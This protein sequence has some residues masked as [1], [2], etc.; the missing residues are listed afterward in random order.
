MQCECNDHATDCDSDGVCL[1]SPGSHDPLTSRPDD[2]LTS[3]GLLRVVHTTPAVLTARSVFL[4]S[5]ATLPRGRP[6]TAGRVLV[7]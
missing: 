5:T 1:V 4:V 6:T 2:P 7:L 3:H